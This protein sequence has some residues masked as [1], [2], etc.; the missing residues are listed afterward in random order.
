MNGKRAT[1][2]ALFGVLCAMFVLVSYSQTFYRAFCAA[3]GYGGTTR[4]ASGPAARMLERT[5]TV[6]FNSDVAPDLPWTFRPMQ[7]EVTVKV[8]ERGLA[9]F[10]ATNN[11]DRAVTGQAT[12][13]VTPEKTGQYFNKIQCFCFNEQTLAPHQTVEM[14]VTFFVDPDIA[15][16]HNDDDVKDIILSYT[17]FRAADDGKTDKRLSRAD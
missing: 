6:R 15:N 7:R 16:N 10:T 2:W 4:V 11:S 1:A 3:T 8:G 9:F 14:P 17:F 13:N 5:M 12:F